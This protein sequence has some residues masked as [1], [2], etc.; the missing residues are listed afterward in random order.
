MIIPEALKPKGISLQ[1]IGVSDIAWLRSDALELLKAFENS[2][3]AV[4][5]GDV[6]KKEKDKY[7]YNYDNWSSDIR[8]GEDWQA[9]A[10]RSR[11]ETQAYIEDYRDSGN[12]DF[13]YCLIFTEKPTL[14]QLQKMNER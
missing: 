12:G 7:K 4:L 10:G 5:G 11:K 13:I 1:N 14:E 3:V 8:P 9:F 2:S 6:L